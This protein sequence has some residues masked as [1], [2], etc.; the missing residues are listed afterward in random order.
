MMCESNL[1]VAAGVER[2]LTSLAN[3]VVGMV[4]VPA[5]RILE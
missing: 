4:V 5:I 1:V 2:L 3:K